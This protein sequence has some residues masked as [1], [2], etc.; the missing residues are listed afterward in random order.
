[1]PA[2][3][4]CYPVAHRQVVFTI[5]K[6]L[7]LHARFDRK[8]LGKLS[9]CAW[10]CIKAETRRML[11]RDD[12]VPGM[13]AAIQ[14]FGQLAQWHPHL[15]CLLTCGAFTPDGDFLK[16]PEFDIDSLLLAWQETVFALY[17]DE[18]KIEPEVVEN[19]RSWDG[20][21]RAADQNKFRCPSTVL[22]SISLCFCPQGTKQE[23]SV[24]YSTWSAALSVC[25]DWSR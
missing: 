18:G 9:S 21:R 7:R 14:T 2:E 22:A 11:G 4:V 15:H 13:I 16:L 3:D 24:W 1:M 12:V 6:R 17:L 23:S 5:P 20:H 19:M 8:L 25:L 10:A